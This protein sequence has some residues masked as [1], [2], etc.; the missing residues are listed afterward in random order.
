MT[1]MLGSVGQRQKNRRYN[2]AQQKALER[3][4]PMKS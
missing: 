3:P 2:T 4:R 1:S